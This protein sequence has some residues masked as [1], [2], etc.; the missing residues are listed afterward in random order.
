[1]TQ[2]LSFVMDYGMTLDAAIHA[3]RIDTSE[4]EIVIG[5]V[6]LPDEVHEVLRARFDCEEARLQ[7]FPGKFASP[8]IV[9]REGTSNF[10]ATEVFHAWGD[11]VAENHP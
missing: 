7:T 8:S 10:G 5:D 1:V 2:L 9:L 11:A 4:G 6:R 3:P